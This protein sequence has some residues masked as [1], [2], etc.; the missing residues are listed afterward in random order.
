MKKTFLAPVLVA[1]IFSGCKPTLQTDQSGE[2]MT[3]D[4][5]RTSLDWPAVYRGVLPC[6]DCADIRTQITLNKD[7]TY[8]MALQ[9]VGKDSGVIT[10]N[11]KLQWNDAG[12]TITLTGSAEPNLYLVGEEKLFKPD[13]EGK[14]I[15]GNQADQYILKKEGNEIVEK[16][17]KLVE[18]RGKKVTPPENQNREPHFILKELDRKVIG[19]GGCNSFHGEYELSAGDR[20]RFSKMASTLMACEDMETEKEFLNVLEMADSYY[21][22]GDTLQLNRARMA[23]LARFAAV[24]FR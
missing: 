14:R 17:W 16:Y 1:F 15:Q 21:V 7:L 5:S 11:G 20:I 8:E 23:P 3:A 2:S 22:N 6:A 12:N 18:L 13:K 24:Y 19:H 4:N 9:Y 10:S